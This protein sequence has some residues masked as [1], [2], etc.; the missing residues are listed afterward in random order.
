VAISPVK[1]KT[2]VIT[3]AS[4][5][6]PL[7]VRL[8]NARQFV[9]LCMAILGPSFAACQDP[10][11]VMTPSDALRAAMAPFNEARSQPDDLTEGDLIALR[12]GT[13]HAAH[14]C[15]SFTAAPTGTE[16]PPDQLLG[17]ARLCLFGQQYEPARA[18]VV[19]YLARSTLP[20]RESG[21]LL[22][23]RAYL[24]LDDPYSAGVQ[25]LSLLREYPYDG[26]IHNAA[27]MVI[28]ASEGL[29]VDPKTGPNQLIEDICTQ[30]IDA[31]LPLLLNGRSLLGGE[32]TIRGSQLFTDALTCATW[33]RGT[34]FKS[35]NH[36][37]DQ[38]TE[39]LKTKDW[40]LSAELPAMQEELAR[41]HML[42]HSVPFGVLEGHRLLPNRRL[43][44]VR[45]GLRHCAQVLIAFTL[46]SPSAAQIIR[47]LASTVPGATIVAM[48]SWSINN[49]EGDTRR[50]L[51]SE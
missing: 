4:C 41:M 48:T 2:L 7:A 24:G 42:G 17:L 40:Q 29:S 25:V 18:T 11:P 6:V 14:D 20:E 13:A 15:L 32:E 3:A 33:F 21:L 38:L 46:W 49:G 34:D 19:K 9:L 27:D 26:K 45:I 44:P 50:E 36:I 35:S 30:E 43:V 1:N 22:L 31:T 51:C 8:K 5:S 28:R 23:V 16:Q 39:S 47:E 12:I 37:I 10:Q